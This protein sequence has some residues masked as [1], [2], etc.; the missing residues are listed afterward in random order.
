MQSCKTAETIYLNQVIKS[1]NIIM[2]VICNYTHQ[3]H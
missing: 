3:L 1:V 2:Q